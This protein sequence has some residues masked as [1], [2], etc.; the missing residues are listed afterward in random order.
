MRGHNQSTGGRQEAVAVGDISSNGAALNL[1]GNLINRRN[2]IAARYQ[3]SQL[4]NGES[5]LE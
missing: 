3:T 1:N 4:G 2:A 5:P